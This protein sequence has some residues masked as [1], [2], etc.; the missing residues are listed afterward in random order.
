[1]KYI[2]KINKIKIQADIN[3]IENKKSIEKINKTKSW[4]WYLEK[5]SKIDGFLANLTRKKT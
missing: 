4:S 2:M 3:T 5:I 1:M